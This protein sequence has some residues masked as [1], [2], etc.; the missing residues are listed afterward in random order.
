MTYIIVVNYNKYEDTFACVDSLLKTNATEI[1]HIVIVDN[2]STNDSWERL[3]ELKDNKKITL[4]LSEENKG[5]CAGNNIGVRYALERMDSD[6]IWILNPDTLVAPDALQKLH[7]FAQTKPD[8]GILG[9]KLVYYPETQYLQGLGGGDFGIQ[10][11][12]ELRPGKYLYH[13]QPSDMKLPEVV[14]L[15][16]IIGASMYIPIKI[17]QTCGLLDERLYMYADESEF[18]FRVKKFGFIHYA[19]SSAVVYHKEGWRLP[20]RKI[21]GIYYSTRNNLYLIQKFFPQNLKWNLFICKLRAFSLFC[22]GRIK[23]AKMTILGIKDFKRGI[24]G[25]KDFD[26]KLFEQ[27]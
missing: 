13:L 19:I 8:L 20:D 27:K 7:D 21:W 14:K 9:C 24:D 5:Y 22:R 23:I 6:F 15:D 3:Q 4:L 1:Y 18:C 25:R 16:L 11:Y 10:K 2:A 26:S 17:F 12:G